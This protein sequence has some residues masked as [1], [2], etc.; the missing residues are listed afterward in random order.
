MNVL[1]LPGICISNTFTSKD[2]SNFRPT[3]WPPHNSFPVVIDRNKEVVSRYG[4]LRWDFSPWHGS[5]LKV[6]FGDGPGQGLKVS[7][8]NAALLRLIMA[9]W[10]WGYGAVTSARTL[11]SKFET[12]KLIFVVCS[13]QKILASKLSEYPEIIRMCAERYQSR[14]GHLISYLNEILF[15]KEYLGFTILDH[16][17]LNIFAKYLAKNIKVQTP[18]IP[19]RIWSYQVSRLKECLEDFISHETEIIA[20]YKFCLKA[21]A[22]N[23]GGD[24][25]LAFKGL[26]TE[27][28]F[29]DV[30]KK[31]KR[32]SGKAFYGS[33]AFTADKYGLSD[34]LEKWGNSEFGI[35]LKTFS[36]YLS[37]ISSVGAAYIANF[38]LMRI[39]EVSKLRLDCLEV[40]VDNYNEEIYLI[41]GITSK[42][43][44]DDDARWIV[45]PTVKV[46]VDAMSI[47]S[48]LRVKSTQSHPYSNLSKEDIKNP[49]LQPVIW[50]P[51]MSSRKNKFD[52]KYK[53]LRTYDDIYNTWPKLFDQQELLITENDLDTAR[54]MT[55]DLDPDIFAVGKKWTLAWH[56]LRRTG[57][58]N[59]LASGLVSEFS[60]QY[61]LKHASQAMSRYYGQNYYKLS[62]PLDVNARNYYLKE[63]YQS[64]VD[65]FK[66][67]QSD[68]FISP[69]SQKRK[70]QILSEISLKDHNQL[71]KAAEAGTI[72]Y[73][74]TYLG[75]CAN[76]GPPCPLGG[77]SNISSCM[78]FGDDKPCKSILVDRNKLK[79]IENLR[80]SLNQQLSNVNNG[81]LLHQSLQAQVESAE[82]AIYVI[83]ES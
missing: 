62:R 73:R 25:S 19:P 79:L 49:L 38:S 32:S 13:E 11:V 2:S 29:N 48:R 27:S 67:L 15:S 39:S 7:P 8:E 3:S 72:S 80:D 23:V 61:Q 56:Q 16:E 31:G 53:K 55:S 14:D 10:I 34:I 77:I 57:A 6:Y 20:C 69:H 78:G 64:I 75:G 71:L 42:T 50:E 26:G 12:I 28:P 46:A 83:N 22:N 74:E 9:W 37:L 4:D 65:D 59:M 76:N 60:L 36:S 17:G 21:Y 47:I 35:T 44:K 82:R 51:W 18:Y 54:R 68:N 43:V 63:M 58:V 70:N 33:F 81:S 52:N 41:K 24:L 66:K 40:E 30:R 45:S 5:T 1:E